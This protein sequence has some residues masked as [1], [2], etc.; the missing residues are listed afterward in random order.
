MN[1]TDGFVLVDKPAGMTSHDTVAIT[2][3]QL[4]GPRAGHTGTLD[5]AA[6]G[7]LVVLLGGATRLARFVPSEPKVYETTIA[8][9]AETSTD[10][11]DG[12]VT[13][14][15]PV[16]D[17]SSVRAALPGLTGRLAQVPPAYSAKQ[18]AGRRAYAAARRGDAIALAPAPVEVHG[19]EVLGWSDGILSARITC[20]AGTYI[21]ALAR[22]L[23]RA[24]GSAAHLTALR[25]LRV[26]P[27]DVADAVDPR[28]ETLRA[29]VQPAAAALV[30]LPRLV[31]DPAQEQL[32]RHG[33]SVA[34]GLA[35]DAV[36]LVNGGGRLIAVAE[37]RGGEFQPRVVLADA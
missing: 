3:R 27:F 5:P 21:R 12:E 13:R 15:A 29:R 23:G 28:D 33:R 16:P 22:D 8:F 34:A 18:V 36:A 26:G 4:D 10:D 9:G 6:T 14:A 32:V 20:G 24:C 25:R 2:R 1:P 37:R 31:L 35:G 7:L 30:D 19:W 17:E 11:A